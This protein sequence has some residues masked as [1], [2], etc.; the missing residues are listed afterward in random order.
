MKTTKIKSF[1]IITIIFNLFLLNF[2]HFGKA[3]FCNLIN[4][5]KNNDLYY[6]ND[7][8]HI[9]SSWEL[10]YN[11]NNEIS[12]IQIRICD[13]HNNIIWNSSKYYDI[14]IQEDNWKINIQDLGL[15][16]FTYPHTLFLKFIN[17]YYHIDTMNTKLIV[18][19]TKEFEILKRE[20]TCYFY[21]LPENETKKITYGES[22]QFNVEFY[23]KYIQNNT[24]LTNEPIFFE[25]KLKEKVLFNNTYRIDT[26]GSIK[27][28]IPASISLKPNEYSL[29]FL[30]KNFTFY[31]DK[32]FEYQIQIKKTALNIN[33][34]KFNEKIRGSD[35]IEI[36]LF[37]YYYYNNELV[38][39][40][41]LPIQLKMYSKKILKFSMECITNQSGHLFVNLSQNSLNF[42][43]ENDEFDIVL[44]FNGTDCLENTTVLLKLKIL[45]PEVPKNENSLTL[46]VMISLIVVSIAVIGTFSVSFNKITRKRKNLAKIEFKY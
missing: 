9:N 10:N 17:F 4:L 30:I 6:I 7:N 12:Y 26:K 1:F 20:I 16:P 36:R 40:S 39:L 14:G 13:V 31:N 41:S 8:I 19:D 24:F 45:A 23:D 11:P 42:L 29:L 38:P 28:L 5:E 15:S 22:F 44:I 3:Y 2:A 35:D 43:K 34:L 18:F 37:Y 25:L 33:I 32:I 21:K 46:W 27:V